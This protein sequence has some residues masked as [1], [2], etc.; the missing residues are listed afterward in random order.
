MASKQ[1]RQYEAICERVIVQL[2]NR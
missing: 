2:Q 1:Q